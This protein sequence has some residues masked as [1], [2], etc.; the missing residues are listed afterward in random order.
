MF[1][2][3][4]S[5]AP[6]LSD[7]CVLCAVLQVST[8]SDGDEQLSDEEV[9]EIFAMVDRNNDGQIDYEEFVQAMT[10]EKGAP[11]AV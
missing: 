8:L 3:T 5:N 1:Y 11:A 6:S 7:L 2:R 4:P 10:A 9:G